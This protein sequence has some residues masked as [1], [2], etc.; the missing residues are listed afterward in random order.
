MNDITASSIVGR[1]LKPYVAEELFDVL[2]KLL[3]ARDSVKNAFSNNIPKDNQEILDRLGT[4][5]EAAGNLAGIAASVKA[6]RS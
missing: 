1:R 2:G 4:L 6:G 5:Y 3:V